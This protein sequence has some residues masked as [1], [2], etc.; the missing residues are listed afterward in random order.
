MNPS[1]E[2]TRLLELVGNIVRSL[3]WAWPD[4]A[5]AHLNPDQ[6]RWLVYDW[7]NHGPCAE[8][9]ASTGAMLKL[10]D[11]SFER[12]GTPPELPA[13]QTPADDEIRQAARSFAALAE[14][15]PPGPEPGDVQH[16]PWIEWTV[17][18]KHLR[19]TLSGPKGRL[20]PVC[21]EIQR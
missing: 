10:A 21:F 11:Q 3:G 16:H 18:W 13:A 14:F 5:R 20:R 6:S 4:H 17:V 2:Q 1:P 8:I 15:P 12:L 19:V 7:I 9:D